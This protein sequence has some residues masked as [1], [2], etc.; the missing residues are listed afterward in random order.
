MNRK[1]TLLLI[2]A[3][4]AI[5]PAVAVAD[6]MIT[7]NVVINGTQNAPVFVIQPGPNYVAANAVGSIIWNPQVESV[8]QQTDGQ[9][10]PMASFDLE[11]IANQ[12]TALANV[13][14]L[15]VTINAGVT[16][17]LYVNF[18]GDFPAG[19][20]VWITNTTMTVNDVMSQTGGQDIN[21]ALFVYSA[22]FPG[23]TTTYYI[24]FYLPPSTA[25]EGASGNITGTFI[26]S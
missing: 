24:S 25:Y 13:L 8:V 2:A 9:I 17:T 10:V 7:G 5:L 23:G 6:V 1:V 22:P 19:A 21:S 4:T 11:G 20:L 14:D 12:T 18:T 15:N 3:V 26:A 16:G